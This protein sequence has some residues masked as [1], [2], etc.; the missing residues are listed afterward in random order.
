LAFIHLPPSRHLLLF[1]P[2][3]F[4]TA[5]SRE[6]SSTSLRAICLPC[7]TAFTAQQ[8]WRGTLLLS[9]W[10]EFCSASSH[11]RASFLP[12]CS[13][14]CREHQ[15]QRPLLQWRPCCRKPRPSPL[16]RAPDL[17]ASLSSLPSPRP[18]PSA[19]AIFHRSRAPSTCSRRPPAT[20]MV[21]VQALAPPCELS[22]L[23]VGPSSLFSL[24]HGHQQQLA[25]LR[26]LPA[27]APSPLSCLC[28]QNLSSPLRLSP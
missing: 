14:A 8:P 3:F 6:L 24:L 28:A 26:P 25:H 13:P 1:L 23:A 4:H 7:P 22:P 15:G 2:V 27:S 20:S 12:C 17:P 9:P 19:P 16:R 11:G 21:G 10:S 18:P 5:C